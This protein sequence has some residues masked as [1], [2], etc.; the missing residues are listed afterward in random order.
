LS[1]LPVVIMANSTC[2]C[3]CHATRIAAA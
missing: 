3:D 1:P 2:Q